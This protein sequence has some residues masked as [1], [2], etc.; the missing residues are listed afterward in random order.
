MS[1]IIGDY[2]YY[3]MG[4]D[5]AYVTVVD[6]TKTEYGT[7]QQAVQIDGRSYTVRYM[8][9]CFHNCINMIYPPTIPSTIT[10]MPHAFANCTALKTPPILPSSLTSMTYCFQGCSSLA[11]TPT[12]PANVLNMMGC[13]KDCTSLVN[14]VNIPPN[15]TSMDYCF[16]NCKSL[17]T[18]PTIPSGVTEFSG[19]FLNCTSLTGDVR[20]MCSGNVTVSSVFAGTTKPIV[21][22]TYASNPSGIKGGATNVI[23]AHIDITPLDSKVVEYYQDSTTG[24]KIRIDLLLDCTQGKYIINTY[25]HT[26]YGMDG[27]PISIGDDVV[28]P[29]NLRCYIIVP[30]TNQIGG[31]AVVMIQTMTPIADRATIGVSSI[32][33]PSQIKQQR[34]TEPISSQIDV[35]NIRFNPK[36]TALNKYTVGDVIGITTTDMTKVQTNVDADKVK[37]FITHADNVKVNDGVTLQDWITEQYNNLT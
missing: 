17:Q 18:V 29:A 30:S 4:G 31:S 22:Y 33:Q 27:N 13:F 5:N 6:R 12:I 24:G 1:I 26:L 36:T 25:G 28:Q 3:S 2:R 32:A 15:V 11:T 16:D 10:S 20:F 34:E 14:V 35:T 9:D 19:C 37:H 23:L 7:I 8:D 21:L